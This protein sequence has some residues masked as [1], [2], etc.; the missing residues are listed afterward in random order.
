MVAAVGVF[1]APWFQRPLRIATANPGG[2]RIAD[3]IPARVDASCL[4]ATPES[5]AGTGGLR[6]GSIRAGPARC[7]TPF[8]R[9]PS[10]VHLVRRGFPRLGV[11]AGD[12]GGAVTIRHGSADNGGQ[13]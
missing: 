12:A 6:S 13:A 9:V 2:K 11:V 10:R 1:C 3:V 7:I 5:V 4:R 8:E